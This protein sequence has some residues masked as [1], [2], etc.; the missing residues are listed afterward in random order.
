MPVLLYAGKLLFL[1]LVSAVPV[2]FLS[3]ALEN[4]ASA[5]ASR[6]V[7][8]GIPLTVTAIVYC[9]TGVFL[10]WITKDPIALFLVQALRKRKT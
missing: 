2:L 6:L 9:F 8:A 10:L 4:M 3:P 5:S 1:S 7:F